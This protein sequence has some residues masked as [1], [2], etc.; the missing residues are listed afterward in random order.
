MDVGGVYDDDDDDYNNEA[1]MLIRPPEG[2]CMRMWGLYTA[3]DA[4]GMNAGVLLS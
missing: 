4:L 2:V 1:I 3:V